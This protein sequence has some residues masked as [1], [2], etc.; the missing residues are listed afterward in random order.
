MAPDGAVVQEA[1]S[2][3]DGFY[4]FEKVRPGRYTLRVAA[5]QLERLRLTAVPADMKV[6][7]RSGEV[8]SGV[9]VVLAPVPIR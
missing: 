9:D 3:F 4:L 7:L 1:K 8:R 6:D 5:E 2:Q